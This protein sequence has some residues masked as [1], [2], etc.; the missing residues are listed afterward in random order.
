MPPKK[1]KD[2]K[3]QEYN[4]EDS[5]SRTAILNI[6]EQNG[7]EIE[8]DETKFA[9]SSVSN[10]N[11]Y[12]SHY[13]LNFVIS[14]A[15]ANDLQARFIPIGT[16]VEYLENLQSNL[17]A[18]V[19]N[20]LQTRAIIPI[21]PEIDGHEIQHFTG[22]F[23][24]RIG[25]I[26]FR[27]IYIDPVGNGL[28]SDIPS[29]IRDIITRTLIVSA[30]QFISTTNRIQHSVQT[31]EGLA[32]TNSHCGPFVAYILSELASGAMKVEDARLQQIIEQKDWLDIAD[33]NEG[34][35]INYG[36]E[37]RKQH[38][39][40]LLEETEKEHSNIAN[41]NVMYTKLVVNFNGQEI[42]FHSHEL[43]KVA[44]E[45]LDHLEDEVYIDKFFGFD[46]E[47]II[48]KDDTCLVPDPKFTHF[49]MQYCVDNNL[50]HFAAGPVPILGLE[51]ISSWYSAAQTLKKL[52]ST[53]S[54]DTYT[55]RWISV[56]GRMLLMKTVNDRSF[57]EGHFYISDHGNYQDLL[58]NTQEVALT[59]RKF[60]WVSFPRILALIKEFSG[61]SDES[62]DNDLY[63]RMLTVAQRQWNMSIEEKRYIKVLLNRFMEIKQKSKLYIDIYKTLEQKYVEL[64]NKLQ[65][66]REEFFSLIRSQPTETREYPQESFEMGYLRGSL[67]GCIE[68]SKDKGYILEIY[69]DD[70][71]E[72]IKKRVVI[73]ITQDINYGDRLGVLR[74]VNSFGELSAEPYR[75]FAISLSSYFS[76]DNIH[77]AAKIVYF[78][79]CILSG[80]EIRE[81][82]LNFLPNLVAAWF[83]GES[84]RNSVSILSGLMLLDLIESNISLLDSKGRNLYDWSHTLIHPDKPHNSIDYTAFRDLYGDEVDLGK[85]DGSH[86]MAH[87]D[88]VQHSKVTLGKGQ[89]LS[90]VRQKEGSIII[91]WLSIL[92]KQKFKIECKAESAYDFPL[93]YEKGREPNYDTIEK[94]LRSS[95]EPSKSIKKNLVQLEKWKL[96]HQ[97]IVPCFK[98]RLSNFDNL[99]D[100]KEPSKEE[101]SVDNHW[102]SRDQISVIGHALNN[103]ERNI[104]IPT[105]NPYLAPVSEGSLES[106]VRTRYSTFDNSCNTRMVTGII[107]INPTFINHNGEKTHWVLYFDIR[108][109]DSL[110]GVLLNPR[111][112]VLKLRGGSY[113]DIM[114]ILAERLK[115]AYSEQGSKHI[116]I[117]HK[118]LDFHSASSN[119]DVWVLRFL[120]QIN[121]RLLLNVEQDISITDI[122][123]VIRET[124]LNINDIRAE[125]RKIYEASV[126]SQNTVSTN[127][128]VSAIEEEKEPDAPAPVPS[129]SPSMSPSLSPT[130]YSI[131]LQQRVIINEQENTLLIQEEQ[132][133]ETITKIESIIGKEA[134]AE[135][136]GW[137][138]Y[139]SK[140]L[141]NNNPL[142]SSATK[143]IQ[144]IDSLVNN[145]EEWLD[146][147]SLYESTD[148]ENQ[149]TIIITQLEHWIDFVASGTTYV[150]S[151][152]RY[153]DFD[154]DYDFGDGG[155]SSGGNNDSHSG[156]QN[157]I[158]LLLPFAGNTTTIQ[159]FSS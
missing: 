35:S 81:E 37:L 105:I 29:N 45:I 12:Y 117:S 38:L 48:H 55:G 149:V 49:L 80:G 14:N 113:Y 13:A 27:V 154:P 50:L 43:V 3:D 148:I 15:V 34:A 135:I 93:I 124:T 22:L 120:E 106:F 63:G 137:H 155:D 53:P 59:S 32:A 103:D 150:G 146:F 70:Y 1:T 138:Q 18:F 94:L 40:L 16:G 56:A 87:G 57:N 102:L 61:E 5:A 85:F 68:F 110:E 119:C 111:G 24:E 90:A 82:K 125:Y 92:L 86:P 147:G 139:I 95:T 69:T 51:S 46:K 28:I 36:L 143:V 21:R 159:D 114:D 145:L 33:L 141:S 52:Y 151:P 97:F 101:E 118:N 127:K 84:V 142:S 122:L 75:K 76:H 91:H 62:I 153:P 156:D 129:T 11:E 134:L 140:A 58:S 25:G 60:D 123:S 104:F 112:R 115:I 100:C 157:S 88:S 2:K 126:H 39:K 128:P 31:L 130:A 107:N 10:S 74:P 6:Q 67:K 83:L 23:I 54:S 89:K 133:L 99:L 131:S 96:L 78:I 72:Y 73:E 108:D 4:I 44:R 136:T 9:I 30:N 66:D 121:K 71:I 98:Q 132:I 42:V 7:H 41:S 8:I 144:I 116:C 109:D 152:P 64:A 19:S 26:Q 77:S 158:S 79:R 47:E 65:Q 20:S 17:T